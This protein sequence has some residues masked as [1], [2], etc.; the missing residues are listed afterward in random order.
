MVRGEN[1]RRDLI[2]LVNHPSV[3]ADSSTSQAGRPPSRIVG[4]LAVTCCFLGGA[5]ST[6]EIYRDVHQV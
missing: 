5:Q 1:P 2:P 4:S 3:M 6:P